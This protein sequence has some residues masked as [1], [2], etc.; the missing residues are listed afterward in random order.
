MPTI[1]ETIAELNAKIED[2][3]TVDEAIDE[4]VAFLKQKSAESPA[5]L[6]AAVNGLGNNLADVKAA[7]TRGTAA[8]N[9]TPT[10]G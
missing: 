6:V 7:I 4:L 3:G 1:D 8:E 5:A 9:E 10:E 2:L